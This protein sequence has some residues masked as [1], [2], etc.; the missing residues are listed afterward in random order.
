MSTRRADRVEQLMKQFGL[1]ERALVR[2][3]ARSDD[4]TLGTL[5]LVQVGVLYNE[6]LEWRRRF[7][8]DYEAVTVAAPAEQ[9]EE[10]ENRMV[11]MEPMMLD[12]TGRIIGRRQVLEPVAAPPNLQGGPQ[13]VQLDPNQLAQQIVVRPTREP[14]VTQFDGTHAGW[15]EFHDMFMAEVHNRQDLN[16]L[17]KLKQ[18]KLACSK[19]APTVLGKWP[20]LAVNYEPA[21]N[22]LKAKFH[23]E[24]AIKH[25]LMQSLHHLPKQARESAEGLRKILDT[26]EMALAQLRQKGEQVQHWDAILIMMVKAALPLRT[27]QAWERERK[28]NEAQTFA[29]FKAWLDTRARINM[30]A[31]QTIWR[32]KQY[33]EPAQAAPNQQHAGNGRN[34][35]RQRPYYNRRHDEHSQRA[36]LAQQ[37]NGQVVP[38][39]SNAGNDRPA[40]PGNTSNPFQR[41]PQSDRYKGYACYGC[42]QVGH[43]A[44]QCRTLANKTI[45]EIRSILVAKGIC[46]TCGRKHDGACPN[47]FQCNRCDNEQHITLLCPRR[48]DGAR[49]TKRRG[50]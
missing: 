25:Q 13:L 4:E 15:D 22:A 27:L 11:A 30:L 1:A 16:D 18:L 8:E 49:G 28:A 24:D 39:P 46:I 40:R 10:L 43:S 48:K 17:D 34:E 23:D 14:R 41:Q 21:W 32:E 31:E 12:A 7:Q 45:D 47:P 44:F 36:P 29:A 9:L 26:T 6:Y 50:Q 42:D 2:V 3:I 33:R 38:G 35:N 5:N 19:Q 20:L 37:Q